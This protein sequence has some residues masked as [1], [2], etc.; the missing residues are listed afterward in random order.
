MLH[1]FHRFLLGERRYRWAIA[2]LISFGHG[3]MSKGHI[4]V[5]PVVLCTYVFIVKYRELS[6]IRASGTETYS[7]ISI[8]LVLAL[9][10]APRIAAGGVSLLTSMQGDPGQAILV[11]D[12]LQLFIRYLGLM[13]WPVGL[14]H[15][16]FT[17]GFGWSYWPLA[18]CSLALFLATLGIGS[19][20]WRRR[21]PRGPVLILSLILML[22]YLHLKPGV[23]YMANRYLFVVMPFVACI[24]LETCRQLTVVI[25]LRKTMR[26]VLVC[27]GSF[28]PHRSIDP[29][30]PCVSRFS[31][32][33]DADDR[34]ISRQLMG[35]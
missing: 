28:M 3:V 24:L 5:S 8:C 26:R 1:S 14:N 34:G 16:Y 12:Q 20:W 4:I 31:Q 29:A 7:L 22:P 35:V 19:Y 23:V 9:I 17:P 27:S 11:G 33:V 30:P 25:S 15:I 2:T 6:K 32:F 10:A 13:L 18:L 21:D